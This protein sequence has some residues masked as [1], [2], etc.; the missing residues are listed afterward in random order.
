MLPLL[1]NLTNKGWDMHVVLTG[2]THGLGRL[3]A[4]DLARQGAELTVVVRDRAKV[5]DLR[6]EVATP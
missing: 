6:R 2:A 5:D 4:L 3:A 1:R